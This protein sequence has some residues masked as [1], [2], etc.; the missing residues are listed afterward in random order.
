MEVVTRHVHVLGVT[1][2]PDGARAA[3]QARNLV[4][5]LSDRTGSFR[6]LIRDRDARFTAAFDEIFASEGRKSSKDPAADAAGELLRREMDTHSTSRVHRPDPHLRRTLPAIGPRRVRQPLQPAPAAPVPP[7]APARP[8]NPGHRP[9]EPPSPAAEDTR[10]RDQRVLP[11][12]LTE[13][14]KPQL[15]RHSTSFEAV[16]ARH[17]RSH[18]MG[19]PLYRPALHHPWTHIMISK[20]PCIADQRKLGDRKPGHPRLSS[21]SPGRECA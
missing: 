5:G 7:A 16:Q 21:N 11:G 19:Q 3:Q 4:M 2:H 8:G 13:I 17:H 18:P 10:R 9:A 12:R 1:E 14:M 20:R 15:K 6:F